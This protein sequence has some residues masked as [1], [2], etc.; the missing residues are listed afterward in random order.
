MTERMT[1]QEIVKA[2][3]K[4]EGKNFEEMYATLH[5]GIA[6]GSVRVIRNN[7][8]LLA[9]I[10]TEPHVADAAL[11]TAEDQPGIVKAFREF[12]KGMIAA[13]FVRLEAD[14]KARS[15]LPMMRRAGIQF[16]VA[17]NRLIVE[18]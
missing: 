4:R 3:C 8:T 2:H 12:Y 9:Y 5:Q 11:I 16:T 15:L 17:G 18:A 13:G 7:N 1:T 10:I 6:D 14:I